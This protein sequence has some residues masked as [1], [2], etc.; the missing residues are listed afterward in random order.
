[1]QGGRFEI[2]VVEQRQPKITMGRS[3]GW[4]PGEQL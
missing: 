2:A 4:A 3:G 1:M